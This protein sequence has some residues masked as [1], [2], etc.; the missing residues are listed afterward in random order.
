VLVCWLQNGSCQAGEL[1]HQVFTIL[2]AKCTN[3]RVGWEATLMKNINRQRMFQDISQ[4][5]EGDHVSAM[6]VACMLGWCEFEC[7]F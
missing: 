4:M 7:V 6:S 3:R 1:C 5:M 2:K